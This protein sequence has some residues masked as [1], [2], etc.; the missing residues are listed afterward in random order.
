MEEIRRSFLSDFQLKL[1]TFFK[2]QGEGG[3]EFGNLFEVFEADHLYWGMHIAVWE[4]DQT[5]GNATTRPEDDV[6]VRSAGGGHGFVLECYLRFP[7][8]LLETGDHVRMVAATMSER[9]TM[10]DLDRAVHG[11]V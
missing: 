7:G 11:L 8:D 2:R 9:R 6:R 3:Q 1:L 4:A 5:G 10:A